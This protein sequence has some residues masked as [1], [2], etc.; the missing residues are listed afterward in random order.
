MLAAV[1][2]ASN[3]HKVLVDGRKKIAESAESG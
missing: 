1:Q 3:G 2:I